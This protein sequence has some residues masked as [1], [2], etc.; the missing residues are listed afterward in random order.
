MYAEP[1]VT[2]GDEL[3]GFNRLLDGEFS[4]QRLTVRGRYRPCRRNINWPA[5]VVINEELSLAATVVLREA[6]A[7][8]LAFNSDE[9]RRDETGTGATMDLFRHDAVR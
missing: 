7:V 1:D 8:M 5:I 2:M 9:E 4:G 6:M 3:I